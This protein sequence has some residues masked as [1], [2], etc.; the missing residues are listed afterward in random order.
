MLRCGRHWAV[1]WKRL[2]ATA[3]AV[4][5]TGATPLLATAAHAEGS[6][7]SVFAGTGKAGTAGDGGP[8]TK[9]K[10]SNPTGIAVAEDGTVYISDGSAHRVRA[11]S[12]KGIISTVAG[13]GQA[14]RSGSR[15]PDRAKATTVDLSVPGNL[16]VGPDGTLYIA[17]VGLRC[18]F[19]LAPSGQ[20]SVVAGN[21]ASGFSGDGGP[22]TKAALARPDGLAVAPD[23]TVYIGD[24]ENQRIRAVS[25][26]GVISTV[27][28]NGGT[29]LTAAG[30]AATTIPVPYPSSLAVDKHGALWIV[31]GQVLQRVQD[32]KLST[33][34]KSGASQ[35]GSSGDWR[36]SRAT[37]WPPHPA[38][39]MGLAAVAVDGDDVYV[40][41][42]D[43]ANV[44]ELRSD[45]RLS[46]VTR[47]GPRFS[48]LTGAVAVRSGTAYL[49]A[50]DGHRVYQRTLPRSSESDNGSSTPWWPFVA[51]AVVLILLAG[52]GLIAWRRRGN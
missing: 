49:A 36:L 12:A 21:G 27:A 45:H 42:Q 6:R 33:V 41:G 26:K 43:D 44:T 22:A 28:G 19:A 29:Q 31:D 39:M 38:P 7:T 9:A 23:N 20:L 2:L 35:H 4:L 13:S 51:G 18:V 34:V 1:S 5:T 47:L 48:P 10:L 32:G 40:V 52:G 3:L 15:L 50:P 46:S 17:D 24:S 25:P 37:T 14:A 30:G 16:A 8:A 11:V